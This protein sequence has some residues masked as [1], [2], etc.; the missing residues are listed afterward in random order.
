MKYIIILFAFIGTFSLNAQVRGLVYTMD[1]SDK[2]QPVSYA[3]IYSKSK[4]YFYA[5]ENGSFEYIVAN[6]TPDTLVISS[7]GFRPDTLILNKKDRFAG[8]EIRLFEEHVLEGVIISGN[9]RT[10]GIERMSALHVERLN[11]GELRKAACC[12]L[13]ESFETN[14]SVDVNMTDAVTGV[15]QIQMLG[16]D[17]KYTQLQF[18]NIP[19]L[20]G[21]ESPFGLNSIPGTW[22]NSI[23]ITKGVGNVVNGYESMA[24]LINVEFLKGNEMPPLFVNLYGNAFGRFEAN[25]QSGLEVGKA[26]KWSTG[27]FAHYSENFAE[28]DYNKDGFRDL[29]VGRLMTVMNRWNY[30]GEKV[31]VAL[32]AR[33]F[34]ENKNGGQINTF[35][36]DLATRYGTI[37]DQVGGEFS[38]KTGFLFKQPYRSLGLI[39]NAKYHDLKFRLSNANF[40][41]IQ[42]RLYGN[43]VYDDIIGNTNHTY[44]TGLSF[45]LDDSQQ[46]LTQLSQFFTDNLLDIVPGA[47]FE[48]TFTSTRFTGVAGLR[49]D[50]HN[51]YKSQLSPRIHGKVV[52]TETSDFR[53]TTGRGWRTPYYLSDNLS[54]LAS[55][56]KWVTNFSDE[57][58]S[59][60][61]VGGSFIQRFNLFKRGGS[62]VVDYYYTHFTNQLM[63]NRDFYEKW[64]AIHTLH[65]KSYSHALQVEVEVQP[66]RDFFIRVA[67]KFLDS[68]QSHELNQKYQEVEFIPRHRGFINFAYQTRN[69]RWKF[70]LTGNLFGKARIPKHIVNGEEV[71]KEAYSKIYPI[72]NG[73]VTYIYKTWEFYLGVENITNYKQANPI[74]EAEN[75]FGSNFD[76]TMVWAPITGINPYIGIRFTLNKKK[77]KHHEQEHH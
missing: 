7:H 38:S 61:N 24:G 33:A 47:F 21:M 17:G 70:D 59:S 5:D 75:P 64:I 10:H 57:A 65:N 63:A 55:N 41:G 32:S 29:P 25:I 69:K 51:R 76:A 30:H 66:A 74:I 52:I 60:W 56:R 22:A 13:S 48:Y 68:K 40:S 19:A 9:K 46:Q 16:L 67:Y 1:G 50:Y 23:Q 42:K 54:L 27:I 77:N 8:F 4:G 62:V 6:K 34:L 44:R 39:V 37:L 11:Q 3:E 12:N 36:S 71:I 20:R 58:E 15:K 31:E 35:D 53:F 26:K 2:K 49:Y 28:I 72:V 43:L 73:Q 18:E 14:A 45:V